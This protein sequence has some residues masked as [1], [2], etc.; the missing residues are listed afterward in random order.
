MR[1]TKVA[2]RMLITG[3]M[4]EVEYGSFRVRRVD[5]FAA[6]GPNPELDGAWLIVTSVGGTR[7]AFR[8][9]DE[10]RVTQPEDYTQVGLD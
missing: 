6:D 5:G 7:F 1:G 3:D 10:V 2:A 9:D 4:F 8:P